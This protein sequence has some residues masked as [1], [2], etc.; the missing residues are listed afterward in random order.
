MIL[1][2]MVYDYMATLTDEITFIWHRPKALSAMAYLVNRYFALLANIY[3]L[4][5]DFMP[6][7]DQVQSSH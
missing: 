4:F 3:G 5:V 6:L 1:G 7:P 2:I